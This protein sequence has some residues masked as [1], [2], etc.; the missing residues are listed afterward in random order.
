MHWTFT[1]KVTWAHPRSRGEN[2]YAR[3][4][5]VGNRGSSPLT[6]GKPVLHQARDAVPRLIPAH[7]G[8]TLGEDLTVQAVKGLIPAHAGKT[9]HASA[10]R[11][12]RWAHPRSRGENAEQVRIVLR[13][14][15]SSPLTRGKPCWRVRSVLHGGLIPAHAGK[16]SMATARPSRNGAHPRS[17][18]EN[19]GRAVRFWSC[20]GSSPLT[21]GKREP[22]AR[23]GE[24]ARLIPAH[25][26]K[27]MS[28][29]TSTR[30]APAHPRSRGENVGGDPQELPDLGSSPLTRGK[31]RPAG[32]GMRAQG[33]I[34]AHAGK[35]KSPR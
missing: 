22:A 4:R 34:P 8:K 33:L 19:S 10:L 3:Y 9:A 15:G 31:P 17:R 1:P 25:A 28:T 6:R 23:L 32:S 20:T 2:G 26:G 21:R 24:P 16:T 18:G 12:S 29:A 14:L 7:A 27:T 13:G 11:S 30:C 35:T 5:L